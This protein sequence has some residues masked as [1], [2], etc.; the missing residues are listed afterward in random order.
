MCQEK[1]LDTS[2]GVQYYAEVGFLSALF[3]V[4]RGL[5]YLFLVRIGFCFGFPDWDLLLSGVEHGVFCQKV[6]VV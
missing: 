5:G 1:I 3:F 4:F 6:S 2:A